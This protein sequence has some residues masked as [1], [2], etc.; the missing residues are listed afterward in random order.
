MKKFLITV[1]ILSLIFLISCAKEEAKIKNFNPAG[2]NSI[3]EV[4]ENL[5][6][7][8]EET[9]AIQV[10]KPVPVSEELNEKHADV[11][12]TQ[13]SSAMVYSVVYDMVSNPDNYRG[14]TVIMQGSFATTSNEGTGKRYYACIIR[15]A[16]ACCAQGIEFEL[17]D[18]GVYPDDYPVLD[19]EIKVMGVFD[20]YN[21]GSYIYCTLKNA[22]FVR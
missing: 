6:K 16:T 2:T 18:P 5:E 3:S 4:I 15:D 19:S 17:K 12:L 8:E 20:T 7:K 14:K 13:L 21:E 11:D 1:S 10:S 9:T 22:E